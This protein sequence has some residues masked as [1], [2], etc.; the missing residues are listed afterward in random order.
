MLGEDSGTCFSEILGIPA[1]RDQPQALPGKR[2]ALAT[3]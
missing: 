2:K 1:T 3:L